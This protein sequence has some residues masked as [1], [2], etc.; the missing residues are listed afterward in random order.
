VP[1]ALDSG[2]GS[3][4]WFSRGSGYGFRERVRPLRIGTNMVP[5]FRGE[6]LGVV[7]TGF[8][9]LRF[10]NQG[11]GITVGGRGVGLQGSRSR[12]RW[13]SVLRVWVLGSGGGVQGSG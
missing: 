9:G 1:C 8:E 2:R 12:N 13:E 7:G 4:S 11:L 3:G 6:G 10:G 5:L